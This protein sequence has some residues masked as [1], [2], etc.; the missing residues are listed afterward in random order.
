MHNKQE[1]EVCTSKNRHLRVMLQAT[2]QVVWIYSFMP[3]S[4]SLVDQMLKAGNP[5]IGHFHR[6][7]KQVQRFVIVAIDDAEKL[8][9]IDLDVCRT[10]D[11]RVTAS[12]DL[13]NLENRHCQGYRRNGCESFST[14]SAQ[15]T[16]SFLNSTEPQSS[17]FFCIG[18]LSELCNMMLLE[19]KCVRYL[20]WRESKLL[21]KLIDHWYYSVRAFSGGHAS[22][23][24][25]R[26]L[27]FA[28]HWDM[29][30]TKRYRLVW[31]TCL[32]INS[33]LGYLIPKTHLLSLRIAK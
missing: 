19:T 16:R 29:R 11:V 27:W 33:S 10:K 15:L 5:N 9:V 31:R 3:T 17:F 6:I 20:H 28:D 26:P 13:M 21:A 24:G 18:I 8:I 30:S 4:V 1:E 14:E 2:T 25:P 32:L 22:S 7:C 12:S 23:W